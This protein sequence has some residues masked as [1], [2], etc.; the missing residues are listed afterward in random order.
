M[1]IRTIGILGVTGRWRLA[2][3]RQRR[4]HVRQ[5]R[6]GPPTPVNLTVY[7]NDS[8]R[9]G[10]ARRRRRRPGGVHRHQPGQPDRVAGDLRGRAEPAARQHRADQPPG[11]HPGDGR[12]PAR[13]LHDRHRPR[14]LHRRLSSPQPS[15]IRPA[16]I[17][18]GRRARA[19]ATRCS[20][21]NRQPRLQRIAS[22]GSRCQ[23]ATRAIAHSL[24]LLQYLHA[25]KQL[26]S[27][28]GTDVDDA[29]PRRATSTRW[30]S[31]C[32]RTATRTCSR[33]WASSSCRSP[34][35]S[36]CTS[37]RTPRRR[38]DAQGGRRAACR[39]R[40]RPPAAP[41]EDLVRRG[42]VDAPRGR[43]GPADEAGQR[44]PTPAA[45]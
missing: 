31:T 36:C 29:S 20:S 34:R 45:P 16:S 10:L 3:L 12:L 37:S 23:L 42:F 18:I 35:S 22:I 21:P 19:P 43:R 41:V 5:Q 44:S 25:C 1:H 17:H 32:T 28:R 26:T 30:S 40:S 33:R 2:R 9:L 13:R 7:I 14:R 38:A 39:S 8:A 6:R 24:A 4:R 11:H 27:S 15:S